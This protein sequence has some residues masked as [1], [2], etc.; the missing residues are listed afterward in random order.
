MNDENVLTITN[1]IIQSST[2][3]GIMCKE[4]GENKK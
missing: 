3:E 1:I 2:N 4:E